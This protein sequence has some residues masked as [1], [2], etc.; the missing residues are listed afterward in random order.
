MKEDESNDLKRIAEGFGELKGEL[1]M[2]HQST[3]RAFDEIRGDMHRME[4]NQ[5]RSMEQ[6]EGRLNNR[7]D[8]IDGR[9][10]TLEKKS[11]SQAVETAKQS[12]FT[13]GVT[14]AITY[15]FIELIK[16]IGH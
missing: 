14:A 9:V 8:G 6:M 15:G 7:M 4:E 13:G 12:V 16:R 1:R 5:R 11:E 3:M 10:E 2:M